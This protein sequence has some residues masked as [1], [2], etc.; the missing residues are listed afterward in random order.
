MIELKVISEEYNGD[1]IFH[2]IRDGVDVGALEANYQDHMNSFYIENI[3]KSN[4]YKGHG[5]LKEVIDHL[6]NVWKVDIGCL[7]LP[8]YRT[9]YEALGFKPYLTQGEDIYYRLEA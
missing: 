5:L 8:K 1:M 9:Y 7:P 3:K 2:I 4:D 6:H